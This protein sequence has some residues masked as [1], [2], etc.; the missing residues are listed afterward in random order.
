MKEPKLV[1][2]LRTE[3]PDV[4]DIDHLTRRLLRCSKIVEKYEVMRCSTRELTEHEE[5]LLKAAELEVDWIIKEKLKTTYIPM[6]DVRGY[7]FKIVLP[8]GRYNNW[9]GQGWGF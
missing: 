7:M 9:G 3:F 5:E 8:S 6:E 4:E 1:D 2:I